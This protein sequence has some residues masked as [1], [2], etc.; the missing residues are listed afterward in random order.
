LKLVSDEANKKQHESEA[1]VVLEEEKRRSQRLGGGLVP[2]S[3]RRQSSDHSGINN[4]AEEGDDGTGG[5][6]HVGE[7]PNGGGGAIN[8]NNLKR[9]TKWLRPRRSSLSHSK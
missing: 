2:A 6:D 5:Q 8:F 9:K 4:V 1:K 7:L 3:I